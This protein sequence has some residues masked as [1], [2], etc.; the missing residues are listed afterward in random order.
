LIA[1]GQSPD[2]QRNSSTARLAHSG[3]VAGGAARRAA[4]SA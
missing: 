3:T 2:M 1:P 4:S